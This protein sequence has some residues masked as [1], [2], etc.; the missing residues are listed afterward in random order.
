MQINT[1]MERSLKI[2]SDGRLFEMEGDR[3]IYVIET[4]GQVDR[5]I[6]V[7][8]FTP[9]N[10]FTIL[11]PG[12][13]PPE[14]RGIRQPTRNIN[15]SG[16]KL[17]KTFE[18]LE[19]NAY[20]DAVGVWTIGYGHTK[21]AKKG[22]TI[23]EA[24]AEELLKADLDLFEVAVADAVKVTINDNQFSALVSFA[25]NLGPR[26]LSRSTLLKLLNNGNI[27][28][29]ADEFPKWNK[30]GGQVLRGLTRRRNAER[31]LF[32]GKPWEPFVNS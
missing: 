12:E 16:L 24:Q 19:L 17:I 10:I 4:A 18:G 32:L 2:T 7:L 6:E 30:A 8:Q 29:A 13:E 1:D 22:M 25:F 15:P 28:G 20:Q 3:T 9:A 31:A 27:Q 5:L 11:P 14:A 23:S 21:T 26:N